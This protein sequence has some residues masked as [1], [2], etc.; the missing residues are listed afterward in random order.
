MDCDELTE[1]RSPVFR[2]LPLL[3]RLVSMP[4]T[5][6]EYGFTRMQMMIFNTLAIRGVLN[7]SQIADFIGA[8]K[9]QTTRAVAPMVDAGLVE[10]TIPEENRTHV[11]IRLTDAGKAFMRD[12]FCDSEARIRAR[13]DRALTPEELAVLRAS[14]DA[15]AEILMK[16]K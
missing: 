13:L 1:G 15:A 2:L 8:S 9:E 7:M 10:R 12:Y 3:H 11:D 4:D 14:I 6:R 5:R 16:V